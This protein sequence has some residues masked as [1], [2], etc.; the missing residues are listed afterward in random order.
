MIG[1]GAV[2]TKDVVDYALMTGV[3]AK[4][5]GWVSRRG[6]RLGSDLTCPETSDRYVEVGETLRPK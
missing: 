6:H 2:I 1:A 5:E 3:P 4:R